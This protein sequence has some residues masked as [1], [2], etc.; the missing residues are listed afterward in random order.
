MSNLLSSDVLKTMNNAYGEEQFNDTN[1]ILKE[2]RE[3][4]K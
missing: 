2:Q 4:D 1:D 3:F